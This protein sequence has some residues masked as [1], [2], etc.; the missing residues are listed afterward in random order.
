MAA[1]LRLFVL[2]VLVSGPSLLAA[3]LS[4]AH[5]L[6]D[7]VFVQVDSPE[8]PR[9]LRLE[10]TDGSTYRGASESPSQA[11][12]TV[13][14]RTEYA[15]TLHLDDPVAVAQRSLAYLSA[16]GHASD[17]SVEHALLAFDWEVGAFGDTEDFAAWF[18]DPVA[19][20]AWA[21]APTSTALA[22]ATAPPSPSSGVSPPAAASPPLPT[23]DA[24]GYDPEGYDRDGYDR[25]GFDRAGVYRVYGPD[26]YDEFGYDREGYDRA[27]FDRYGYSRAG[28]DVDGYDREGFDA[29]GYTRFDGY[30]YGT[31]P[32]AVTPPVPEGGVYDADGYGAD[33]YDRQGFD[34]AGVY[35]DAAPSLEPEPSRYDA[36]GFDGST[37]LH[38]N[39]SYYD[40][41][42]YDIFG[43]D[44][45]GFDPAGYD[46]DGFDR[47]GR[48]HL[49][50]DT[51][52]YD[53]DGY[54]VRGFNRDGIHRNRTLYD[55]AGFDIQGYD[56]Q[57]R[58]FGDFDINAPVATPPPAAKE[59]PEPVRP[60]PIVPPS[61][62]SMADLLDDEG[63]PSRLGQM[64]DADLAGL[65]ARY[66]SL[67]N[68]PTDE[69]AA[70]ERGFFEYSLTMLWHDL[71]GRIALAEFGLSDEDPEELRSRQ[72]QIEA[73]LLDASM[74]TSAPKPLRLSSGPKRRPSP[75]SVPAAGVQSLDPD[76]DN[77]KTAAWAFTKSF[78]VGVAVG[79]VTIAAA[80]VVVSVGATALAAAGMSAAAISATG[81]VLQGGA[82]VYALYDTGKTA[83]EVKQDVDAGRLDA[84]ASKAGG[85]LGAIVGGVGA[86]K[87]IGKE[88][89]ELA[90]QAVTEA[91]EVN[92]PKVAQV[93]EVGVTVD[94]VLAEQL[95]QAKRVGSALKDDSFHRSASFVSCEQ[96]QEGRAF[97]LK[98]GDGVDRI[99]LQVKGGLNGRDGVFE[100]ILDPAGVVSHQRFIPDGKITGIPNQ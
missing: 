74:A 2:L 5:R 84:A 33:G 32:Q 17:P 4:H 79:A 59:Q 81:A 98:G 11:W 49:G 45:S 19:G 16:D 62:Q 26:G 94:K 89:G 40:D 27:G 18:H 6:P 35:R 53:R 43:Y 76:H 14:E 23:Y 54:N 48:N 44:G 31:D 67:D 69:W 80:P 93:A 61:D 37:G 22:V 86:N 71:E 55:D 73:Y 91:V 92:A 9:W 3:G 42:G 78:A 24:A 90:N 100:Y 68:I 30:L 41:Q 52:G 12:F 7:A 66:G 97:A 85:T 72:A 50:V 96:L 38:A 51:Q 99:L 46:H 21:P 83:V 39:G 60:A 63:F 13:T 57:G 77:W 95:I 47:D 28:L 58:Y 88:V 36:R 20:G 56:R 29:Q 70:L 10:R 25:M 87:V 75:P 65:V 1:F 8:G 82:V 34:R 15:V 64:S